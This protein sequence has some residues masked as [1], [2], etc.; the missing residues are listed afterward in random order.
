MRTLWQVE[1]DEIN[2]ELDQRTLDF[3]N[4]TFNATWAPDI[5]TLGEVAGIDTDD[6][7][8]GEKYLSSLSY[9]IMTSFKPFLK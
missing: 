9:V 4:V 6:D 3:T 8:L 1:K 2:D 7:G 5:D